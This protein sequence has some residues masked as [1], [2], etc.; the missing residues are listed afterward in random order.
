MAGE[1]RARLAAG[2]RDLLVK[3]PL[4]RGMRQT[5]LA[6]ALGRTQTFVSNYERGEQRAGLVDFV[7]ISRALGLDPARLLRRLTR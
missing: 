2:L 1:E 7:Q 3:A 4:G 6:K 5:E